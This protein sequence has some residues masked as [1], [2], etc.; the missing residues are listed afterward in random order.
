VNGQIADEH[1]V[2]DDKAE[3]DHAWQEP[4]VQMD[5]LANT[6]KL[7][8]ARLRQV[9]YVK[10]CFQTGSLITDGKLVSH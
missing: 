1:A 3:A 7:E 2:A 6:Y 8:N 10:K 5:V 4:E 9:A